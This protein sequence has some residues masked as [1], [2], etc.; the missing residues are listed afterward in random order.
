MAEFRLPANSRVRKEGRLFKAPAGAKNIRV[1]KIYRFDPD[2]AENPRLDSYE[3]DMDAC[4]PMVLDALI[5]IKNE[6]DSTLSFRRSC[7]EGICGSCAMNIDGKNGL[8][9]VSA[10]VSWTCMAPDIAG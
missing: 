6:I 4:G 2:S 9:C 10:C 3:V 7:R 1:F 8:A 5:K